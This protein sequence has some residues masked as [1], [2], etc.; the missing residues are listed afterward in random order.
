MVILV[1]SFLLKVLPAT[2]YNNAWPMVVAIWGMNESAVILLTV[3]IIGS[4][5]SRVTY[6]KVSLEGGGWISPGLDVFS[7]CWGSVSFELSL[8]ADM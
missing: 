5:F 6:Y 7:P 2:N 1:T 3:G 8:Y 4:I